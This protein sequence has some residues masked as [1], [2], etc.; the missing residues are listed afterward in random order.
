P[1]LAVFH[2]HLA[3][4][5][6]RRRRSTLPNKHP[7]VQRDWSRRASA[8][9]ALREYPAVLRRPLRGAPAIRAPW[10]RGDRGR[11][12]DLPRDRA[13]ATGARRPRSPGASLKP[14]Q[15]ALSDYAASGRKTNRFA[16][17]PGLTASRPSPVAFRN[18]A[19]TSR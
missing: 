10:S 3:P 19:T 6:L 1:T 7:L 14:S 12:A 2:D 15:A 8:G 13:G 11:P 17:R 18:A 16:S 9:L 4:I 5:R